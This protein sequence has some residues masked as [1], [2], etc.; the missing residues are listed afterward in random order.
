ME[1]TSRKASLVTLKHDEVPKGSVADQSETLVAVRHAACPDVE[2]ARTRSLK[3]LPD[4]V[5]IAEGMAYDG[6]CVENH[7]E[8]FGS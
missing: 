4:N 6:L 5:S 7:L 1:Q 2:D 3:C 8:R